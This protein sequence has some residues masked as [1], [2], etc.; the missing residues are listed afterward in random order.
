M[1]KLIGTYVKLSTYQY[2]RSSLRVLQIGLSIFNV[3]NCS[4]LVDLEGMTCR[5]CIRATIWLVSGNSNVV[6][7]LNEPSKLMTMVGPPVR[8]WFD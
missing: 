7:V 8:E 1:R 5:G 4:G 2:T 6:K 3:S